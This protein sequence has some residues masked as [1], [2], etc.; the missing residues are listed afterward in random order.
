MAK[1]KEELDLATIRIK[2]Y[3]NRFF[4]GYVIP[5]EGVGPQQLGKG[6]LYIFFFI[7]CV[8]NVV[9]A[10]PLVQGTVRISVEDFPP[11]VEVETH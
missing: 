2:P 10:V 4:P 6:K 1:T 8:Y 5:T 7:I 9:P 3:W 11:A